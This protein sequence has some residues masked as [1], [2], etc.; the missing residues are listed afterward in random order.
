MARHPSHFRRRRCDHTPDAHNLLTSET[1]HLRHCRGKSSTLRSAKRAHGEAADADSRFYC[2]FIV[3]VISGCVASLHF[4]VVSNTCANRFITATCTTAT[5]I[6]IRDTSCGVC[7]EAFLAHAL[8]QC[9]ALPAATVI[10]LCSR[11]ISC[12]TAGVARI[13]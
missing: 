9:L 2:K 4:R 11:L 7:I 13:C 8:R 10:A 3:A 1:H 12:N 5:D 6:S